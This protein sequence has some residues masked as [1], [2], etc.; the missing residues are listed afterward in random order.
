ML[1]VIEYKVNDELSVGGKV[2][3]LLGGVS[4]T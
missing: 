2:R 1:S 3:K 4:S